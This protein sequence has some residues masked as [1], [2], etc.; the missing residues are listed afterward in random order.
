[1]YTVL[2]SSSARW[3]TGHWAESGLAFTVPAACQAGRPRRRSAAA[4]APVKFG[5]R[6]AAPGNLATFAAR[7][8]DQTSCRSAAF[9]ASRSAGPPA[10]RSWRGAGR[11]I[12]LSCLPAAASDGRF[13][14]PETD[15]QRDLEEAAAVVLDP[16]A[17]VGD[18]EPV[19]VVQGLGGARDR[20]P[21]RVVDALRG[22]ADDLADG[23]D[24]V[25]H[26]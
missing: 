16:A 4:S 22:G 19:E 10:S 26:R 25:C 6:P 3:R 23:V 12:P 2:P 1:M 24:A 20:A 14:Q 13:V 11:G 17:H 18:L 5:M 15:L 21:D 9:A 8:A 7:I